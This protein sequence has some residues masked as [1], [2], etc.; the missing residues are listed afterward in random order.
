MIPRSEAK[1]G[2]IMV[3][4][5]W[6]GAGSDTAGHVGSLARVTG[7]AGGPGGS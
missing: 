7:G 3:G 6:E 1:F 2:E 4:G 5:L